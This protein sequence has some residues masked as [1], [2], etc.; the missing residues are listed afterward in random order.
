ML[1]FF[2]SPK[3]YAQRIFTLASFA[4]DI[5]SNDQSRPLGS[6]PMNK[7]YYDLCD[8]VDNQ[9]RNAS[10]H[11]G[12]LYRPDTKEITYQVGKGGTGLQQTI[13][14]T[15]YLLLCEKIFLSLTVMMRIELVLASYFL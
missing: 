12:F 14:Y 11:G 4:L 1:L 13:S 10:H 2:I 5:S 8:C 3:S 7:E 6:F 9:I 15:N